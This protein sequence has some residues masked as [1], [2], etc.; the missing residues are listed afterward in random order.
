MVDLKVPSQDIIT[1]EKHILIHMAD[2][3]IEM[4]AE[5]NTG[6]KTSAKVHINAAM[7]LGYLR[8]RISA[9]YLSNK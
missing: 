4:I 2:S 1:V 6:A 3:Q 5:Y 8:N 7:F 9:F